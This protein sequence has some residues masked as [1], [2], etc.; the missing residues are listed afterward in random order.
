M[1]CKQDP[2]AVW[3]WLSPEE[4]NGLTPEEAARKAELL[5]PERIADA[6]HRACA[7][8]WAHYEA[9]KTRLP[10]WD[11]VQVCGTSH[12]GVVTQIE[13][14]GV[15]F[16]H[17]QAIFRRPAPTRN[18]TLAIVERYNFSF[19]PPG[20][21]VVKGEGMTAEQSLADAWVRHKACTDPPGLHVVWEPDSLSEPN[22]KGEMRVET[23]IGGPT[24]VLWHQVCR[25]G[26]L[27]VLAKDGPHREARLAAWARY[28]ACLALEPNEGDLLEDHDGAPV[29]AA[30]V[31]P[32]CLTWSSDELASVEHWRSTYG[33]AMPEV[34]RG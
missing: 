25:A 24:L 14:L 21:L 5:P 8:A 11:K 16:L 17:V 32:L 7:M 13:A 22:G 4:L 20:G 33:E 10:A 34:L 9:A 29:P 31:W 12:S 19:P 2:A 28:E 18:V 3:V 6:K 30:P 23:S 27:A 15:D 26:R 1:P